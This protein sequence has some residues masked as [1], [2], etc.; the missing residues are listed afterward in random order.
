MSQ[1]IA[2]EGL[3]NVRDLGGMVGAGGRKIRAGLLYRSDQLYF[4]TEADKDKLGEMGIGV[5]VDFR[6]VPER[7]EKPDPAI[8]G[9][10]NLHLPIIEDVRTGITRGSA[11][12][13]RMVDLVMS[14]RVDEAL[15]VDAG[16]R[17]TLQGLF[18]E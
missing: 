2:F 16:K 7:D 12:D 1:Q 8:E 9:A 4:A 13:E 14:G 15:G 6:S 11:G 3:H 5:V 10:R 17:E 18:L